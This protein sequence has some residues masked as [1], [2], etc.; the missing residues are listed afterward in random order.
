R[1]EPRFQSPDSSEVALTLLDLHRAFLIVVDRAVF[2]LR[3][4]ER[5]HLFYD[6]WNGIGIR[7]DR[8]R[9]RHATERPHAAAD[10]LGFFAGV[11]LVERINQ[12][13]GAIA[14]DSLAL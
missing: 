1:C 13:D 11:Q 12:Y 2:A 5:N 8:S 14:H 3:S 10:G 6:L 7:S 9:A 4:A